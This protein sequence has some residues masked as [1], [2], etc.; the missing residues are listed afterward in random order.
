MADTREIAQR[1]ENL[2]KRIA[3]LEARQPQT[4]PDAGW[5]IWMRVREKVIFRNAL[6]QIET[7]PVA[8]VNL[9]ARGEPL[10]GEVKEVGEKIVFIA[11]NGKEIGRVPK[12]LVLGLDAQHLLRNWSHED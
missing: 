3:A 12:S 6:S 11:A 4:P 9:L 1:I 7:L 10:D 5:A 8:L 2:E